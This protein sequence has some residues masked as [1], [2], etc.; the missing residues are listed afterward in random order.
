MDPGLR[1]DDANGSGTPYSA[2]QGRGT[3]VGRHI[4]L[5]DRG[6]FTTELRRPSR[7]TFA[8]V[9]SGAPFYSVLI[10]VDPNNLSS[11]DFV[12][13]LCTEMPTLKQQLLGVRVYP[14]PGK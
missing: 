5:C 4:D 7:G 13:D 10:R 9:Y 6:R 8:T 12:C 2:G 1:R 11:G 14:M 3:E